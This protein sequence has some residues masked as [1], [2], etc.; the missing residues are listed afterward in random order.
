M[1]ET[2]KRSLP[3]LKHRRT[4]IASSDRVLITALTHL[5]EGIGPL[6]G[7]ATSAQDA[8]NCLA[9]NDVQ[10]LVCTDLL[11]S[12]SG[13]ALVTA[14][15]ALHPQLRCLMLIQRPLLSTVDAAIASGCEGL[16]SRERFGDGGVLSVLQAMESDG[17]HMDPTITGVCHHSR[18]RIHH[19]VSPLTDVLSLREED[20][21]RGLCRG[22]S[23]Q[24]IADQ[25]H[26]AIDTIKHAVTS[27]LRKLEARDRT[28]AV[29]IAFQHNLVDPPVPI[30]RWHH[31]SNA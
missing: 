7:A 14:A 13:P 11:D 24:E 6:V 25:L 27:L 19:G 1:R 15:K 18:R 16:C 21:L 9:T 22:L 12:G 23:N 17:L 29:L 2:R 8:L 26:L 3:L 20:V 28:Q 30:P 4:V 10:L 5:F 31:G